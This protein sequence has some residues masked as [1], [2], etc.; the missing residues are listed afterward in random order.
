MKSLL[1]LSLAVLV[2]VPAFA[3]KKNLSYNCSNAETADPENGAFSLTVVDDGAEVDLQDGG[4]MSA[5]YKA[6]PSKDTA[7]YA[8]YKIFAKDQDG[9][10]S[11]EVKVHKDLISG[12]V[13]TSAPVWLAPGIV[14]GAY[15]CYPSK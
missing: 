5:R 12:K 11:A 4:E 7:S 1:T 10:Q 6:D 3:A 2:S 14:G 13:R 9:E 15:D 8:A